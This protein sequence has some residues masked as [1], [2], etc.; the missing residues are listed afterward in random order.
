[1][2]IYIVEK[3][4]LKSTFKLSSFYFE[5]KGEM[6]QRNIPRC[7]YPFEQDLLNLIT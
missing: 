2:P 7:Q 6:P 1:M 4:L 5:S 3:W